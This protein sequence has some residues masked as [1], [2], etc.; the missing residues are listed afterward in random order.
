MSKKCQ[1]PT[2]SHPPVSNP[3]IALKDMEMQILSTDKAVFNLVKTILVSVL[4]TID[5]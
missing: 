4:Y 5:P 1:I 2:T 3:P